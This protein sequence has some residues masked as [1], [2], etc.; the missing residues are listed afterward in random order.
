[1]GRLIISISRETPAILW[2]LFIALGLAGCGNTRGPVQEYRAPATSAVERPA[3]GQ[4]ASWNNAGSWQIAPVWDGLKKRLASDGLSGSEV[5]ALLA[6]LGSVPTQSPMGRKIQELYQKKFYPRPKTAKPAQKYYKGVVTAA[7]AELCREFIAE[8]KSAFV[9]AQNRY[10]VPESIAAALLFV[11]TRLGRA[12]AD[13]PENAFFTLASMAISTKPA[14]ID[15]WLPKLKNYRQHLAWIEET[16]QKR[17]NW[18]YNETRA[19]LVHML[20]DTIAPQSLPS[21]IY[22]AVG[23]CQF[24]P[25]NISVY[26]ADGDNDGRVDLFNVPDA[27]ASLANYLARHGWKAGISRERQH[28]LLMAY[29]HSQTYAN[30]I[31]ALADL[32][33]KGNA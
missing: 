3:A 8:H 9:N 26:G 25:S 24:M 2:L 7:N 5:D 33:N 32:V 10:G 16:M 1:M 30:T 4:E 6:Q 19:L 18:A 14:D 31:M 20:K 27:V 29:N 13:V 28:K 12:L 22:G 15:Q 11:E 17:A 21:S 23:L